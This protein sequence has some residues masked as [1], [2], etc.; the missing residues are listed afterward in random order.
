[1]W[2][3]L[4]R[5]SHLKTHIESVQ[6]KVKYPCNQCGKQLTSKGNLKTRI[7]SVHKKLKYPY[8]LCGKQFTLQSRLKKTYWIYLQESLL[9]T[10]VG[11]G[12]RLAGFD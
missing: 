4:R 7:E 12:R 10:Q 6:E 5:K 8:Y 3:T 9:L 11:P 1:M 2:Q